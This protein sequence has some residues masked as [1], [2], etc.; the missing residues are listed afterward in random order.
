M[1]YHVNMDIRDC[2]I[3]SDKVEAALSAIN[4]MHKPEAIVAN[5]AGGRSGGQRHY[6]WVENPGEGGFATLVEAFDAWR[7]DAWQE[8]DGSVTLNCFTGEKW[9]DDEVLIEALSPFFQN[10]GEIIVTGEDGDIWGYRFD[11]D[12]ITHGKGTMV[13][14]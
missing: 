5:N 2:I 11:E 10:G 6:G 4:A 9:G 8:L 1:G 13:W 14:G 3:P 12:G 7:Y